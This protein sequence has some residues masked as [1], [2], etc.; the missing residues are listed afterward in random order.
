[1]SRK[2]TATDQEIED[3]LAFVA[4]LIDR[5]G[6]DFWPVF[7]RLERELEE[8]RSRAARLQQHLLRTS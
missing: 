2:K 3:A 6:Y 1:M 5:Y 4:G 7:D 8:R